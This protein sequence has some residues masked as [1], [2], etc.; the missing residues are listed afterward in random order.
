MNKQ[1]VV[2]LLAALLIAC[3]TLLRANGMR[4]VSQDG[5]A[6]AR[7]EA[8]AATADNPSAIYYNPAGITQLEGDNLRSGIYALYYDTTYRPPDTAP[9]SGI[10]YHSSA[11]FAAAT[12]LFYTHTFQDS[13]ISAGFGIYAPYGAGLT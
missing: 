1:R 10:T 4:L 8:F 2:R 12:T 3:P 9:N 6:S 13:P 11:D 5:F 7:G